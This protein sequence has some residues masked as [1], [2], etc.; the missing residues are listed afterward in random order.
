M[1]RAWVMIAGAAALLLAQ[2]A[3]AQVRMRGPASSVVQRP[4]AAATAP[5]GLKDQPQAGGPKVSPTLGASAE[6][7]DARAFLDEPR[8]IRDDARAYVGAS[9]HAAGPTSVQPA[10]EHRGPEVH[11]AIEAGLGAVANQP[12]IHA[13]NGKERAT[14]TPGGQY[15]IRG[16]GFTTSPG[17][18]TLLARGFPGGALPLTVDSWSED[19][20]LASVPDAT[21]GV[22]DTRVT[23]KVAPGVGLSYSSGLSSFVARRVQMDLSYTDPKL[24]RAIQITPNEVWRPDDFGLASQGLVRRTI[25]G[26]D[27]TCP[28]PGTD[29]FNV[30]LKNGWQVAGVQLYLT[31]PQT[32]DTGHDETGM[33]GDTMYAGPYGIVSVSQNRIVVNWGVYRSHSSQRL[34]QNFNA[35][36]FISGDSDVSVAAHDVCRSYYELHISAVGPDGLAP[37]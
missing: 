11:Q 16:I 21:R 35:G 33:P 27:V 5:A 8:L 20:I 34:N 2:G 10:R 12:G 9:A 30:S 7:A 29:G 28:S 31:L 3:S 37:Y 36:R 24:S 22:S 14:F 26:A 6:L 17:S 23:L 13:V 15:E 19:R 18:V 25:A 4:G 32:S 1:T